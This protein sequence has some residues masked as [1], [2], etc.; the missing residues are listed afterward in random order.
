M[1]RNVSSENWLFPAWK[2]LKNKYLYELQGYMEYVFFIN[3]PSLLLL[4]VYFVFMF[5][6]NYDSQSSSML[7]WI[8]IDIA[9][10][11]YLV[12]GIGISLLLHFFFGE[13]I[14][15]YIRENIKEIRSDEYIR[16]AKFVC[17]DE[18]NQQFKNVTDDDMIEI[19]IVEEK[20]DRE[21]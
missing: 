11:P 21:F 10:V 9:I 3:I 4:F 7:S 14:A 6:A 13:K 16:G 5:E 12:I 8:K 1:F 2:T 18:F 17:V 20:C 19:Q 15:N